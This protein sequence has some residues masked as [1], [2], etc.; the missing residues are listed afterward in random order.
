[1]ATCEE[2]FV[3]SN[4]LR[5]DLSIVANQYLL[6]KISLQEIADKYH[7]S[8][9]TVSRVLNREAKVYRN[10]KNQSICKQNELEIE[11]LYQSG[12]TVTE[13]AGKIGTTREAMS[14]YIG[15]KFKRNRAYKW[16]TRIEEIKRLYVEEGM[17]SQ[18]LASKYGVT[19]GAMNAVLGR[20]HIIKTNR[21][22]PEKLLQI[23]QDKEKII[24]R[25]LTEKSCTLVKISEEYGV[26]YNHIYRIMYCKWRVRK[27]DM[28]KN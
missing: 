2:N 24:D 17:T 3:R 26:S 13:I 23:E 28:I 4:A 14:K 19:K 1:M 16:G 6:G 7:V 15:K 10:V 27:S 5:A 22:S 25:F 20:F 18:E 12:H 9:S 8:T 11:N 21:I